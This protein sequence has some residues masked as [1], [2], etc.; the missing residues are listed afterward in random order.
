MAYDGTEFHG[1][2]RQPNS[3]TVQEKVESALSLIYRKPIYVLGCGRTDT[4]VHASCF[5]FHVDLDEV[6]KG[7][8]YRF[9][10]VLPKSITFYS[11]HEV[12][13]EAHSRFDA[14]ERSYRYYAHGMKSP[15]LN[16]YSSEIMELKRFNLKVDDLNKV[17]KLLLEYKEFYPFCKAHADSNTYTCALSKCHWMHDK[18]SD[19]FILDVTSDRFL[20]GMIRLI[21]GACILVATES[22]TLEEVKTSMDK[23]KRMVKNLSGPPQGLFLNDVQYP[24]ITETL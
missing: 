7:F 8:I 12:S 24:Y 5:Y 23:Q 13:I 6:I 18:Q 14:T 4:G 17:A 21:V 20:R 2:A 19:Q 22:L 15:F 16:R 1:W 3:V 9:N 11:I 10:T